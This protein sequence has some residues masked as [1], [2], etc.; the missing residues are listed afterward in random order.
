MGDT[1]RRKRY[2]TK[3]ALE[4]LFALPSDDESVDDMEESDDEVRDNIPAA[5][6][7]GPREFFDKF[8]TDEVVHLLVEQ[9][10]LYAGQSKSR[11]WDD[12]V[13]DEIRSF[14][15]LLIAMG[16][17][18]LPKFRLYW[19]TNP[20][21]RVQ[22]VVDVMTRQRFMKLLGN[23]HLNDNSKAVPRDD[24]AYDK[25]H[26][27]RPLLTK[28]NE[29]F[30]KEAVSSSSQSV[31]EAM[32]LFKGRSSFRQYM[33]LKPIKRGYKV[34][35]RADSETGYIY[36]FDLYTGKDDDSTAGVG[37]GSRVVQNLTASLKNA[38]AHVTFDN[39]FTSVQLMEDLRE[40]KIFATGTVRAIRRDL[41]VL[42]NEKTKLVKGESK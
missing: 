9:T 36:Q 21:F 20:L 18:G 17:H 30:Q 42:A 35:V 3:E 15:G 29:N 32:I 13:D 22:P 28:M 6:L 39:F 11:D 4:Q 19:S 38:N 27:L 40:N 7:D 8:F 1:A 37:L 31:D 24:P 23:L 33:P 14:L 34:W 26:K 41:P 25:L 2:T 5:G 16:L 12:A 10:N